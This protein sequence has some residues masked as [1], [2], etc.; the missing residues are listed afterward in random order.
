MANLPSHCSLMDEV[1]RLE[2]ALQ[3]LASNIDTFVDDNANS[4]RR[5]ILI[6]VNHVAEARMK[7]GQVS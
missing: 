3:K 4:A 5:S 6:A 1:R 7:L 2:I